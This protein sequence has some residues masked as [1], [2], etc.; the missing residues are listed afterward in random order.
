M[1]LNESPEEE[2]GRDTDHANGI[3]IR[4]V[5]P[6]ILAL[7]VSAFVAV[8]TIRDTVS[9]LRNEIAVIKVREEDG[10]TRNT[11]LGASIHEQAALVQKLDSTIIR[12]TIKVDELI[13]D[14]SNP[15]PPRRGPVFPDQ[16]S[17]KFDR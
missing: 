13:E 17:G 8:M 5:V 14:R 10:K 11:E 2:R 15:A 7:A 12:L 1:D 4:W 6:L 16:R 9:D 3:W